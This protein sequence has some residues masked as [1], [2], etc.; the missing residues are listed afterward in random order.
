MEV[1]TVLITIGEFDRL[2]EIEKRLLSDSPPIYVRGQY[3]NMH[4]Y[5]KDQVLKDLA[6]YN[7][8]L[9]KEIKSLKDPNTNGQNDLNI[10]WRLEIS[11]I[12]AMSW[13]QFCKWRK[14]Q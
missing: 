10:S 8:G 4:I 14:G 13:W 11:K 9:N 3:G 6:V 5:T 2:R 12:K 7:D 1:N